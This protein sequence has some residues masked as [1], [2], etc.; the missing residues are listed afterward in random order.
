M[1]VDLGRN[2]I[3]RV[4]KKGSVTVNE[5][6]VIERY[7]HVIHLVSN[8]IGEIDPQYDG[9]DVLEACFPAGTVSGAPKI[10]SMEIIEAG[11]NYQDS[12]FL[13]YFSSKHGYMYYHQDY[14]DKGIRCIYRPWVLLPIQSLKGILRQRIR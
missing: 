13:G 10:R 1:L 8:V 11:I 14:R 7:S 6:M 3:G 5:L 12:M 4:C 9:F 2:D